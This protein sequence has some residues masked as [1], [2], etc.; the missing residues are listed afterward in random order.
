MKLQNI[1]GDK[2]FEYRCKLDRV[3]DGDTVDLRVDLGFNIHIKER[4]RLAN[5]DAPESRTRNREEKKKGLA[6]TAFL[7]GLLDTISMKVKT[8]K[9]AKGKYG[10]WIGTIYVSESED[11][12]L[13]DWM[14][15][16][17][18]MIE[19]GYAVFKKY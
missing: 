10:R 5:I 4:F 17:T 7:E 1:R 15:V 13:L 3:V 19:S 12:K 16:N 9:D 6:S 11:P 2:M 18:M 8:D 14:D